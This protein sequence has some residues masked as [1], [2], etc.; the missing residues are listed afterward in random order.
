[1]PDHASHRGETDVEF[2]AIR[3]DYANGLGVTITAVNEAV[4]CRDHAALSMIAH[5]TR[6]AAGMYGCKE[7]SATAGLLEDAIHEGQDQ[8]VVLKLA[9]EFIRGMQAI[10]PDP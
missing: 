7:L 8:A 1:M 4:A 9:D 10:S 6:G 2:A 5:Q 3:R